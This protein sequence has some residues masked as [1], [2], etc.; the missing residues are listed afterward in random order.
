[1]TIDTMLFDLDGTLADSA[2]LTIA[3]MG[4]LAPGESLPIPTDEAIRA[5]VGYANPEFYYRLFPG[6]PQEKIRAF[7][8][9]IEAHE[10]E[11]MPSVRG[12]LLFP[13][14]R[15]ML[16]ALHSRGVALFIAST[17]DMGHVHA[18]IDQTGIRPFFSG[19]YCNEPDK[20]GMIAR[21]LAEHGGKSAVMVGDME[22]DSAGA[23]ANG[24]PSIGACFGYCPRGARGFDRYIDTPGELVPLAS[25]SR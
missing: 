24:L 23:R 8:E 16:S 1:M 13:G 22:K 4:A 11:I 19:I 6:H 9:K 25:F 2:V 18:V 10:L 3:A 14:C 12:R 21:I 20:E 17:G 15:E 5:A 7:G